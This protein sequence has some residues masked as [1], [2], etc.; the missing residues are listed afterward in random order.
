MNRFIVL[1]CYIYLVP[2]VSKNIVSPDIENWLDDLAVS[3]FN[4]LNTQGKRSDFMRNFFTATEQR[5]FKKRLAI[6]VLI[7]EE[8]EYRKISYLLKV[9]TSTV[10]KIGAMYRNVPEFQKVIDLLLEKKII[11]QN[12]LKIVGGASSVFGKARKGG[13]VWREISKEVDRESK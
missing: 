1:V 11:R 10:G 3:I 13:N 4:Q 6:A 9:S 8:Y 5:M 2:Q 12:I 7:A